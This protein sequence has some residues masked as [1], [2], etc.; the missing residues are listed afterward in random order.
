MCLMTNAKPKHVSPPHVI[1]SV[2]GAV[3]CYRLF[4]VLP[5]ALVNSVFSPFETKTLPDIPAE[6][7]Q[8]FIST[9]KYD[10]ALIGQSSGSLTLERWTV[11]GEVVSEKERDV[12][13]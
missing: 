6:L 11:R 13:A 3:V 1:H 9:S 7:C 4:I 5:Q 10:F 2:Y 12:S 8:N